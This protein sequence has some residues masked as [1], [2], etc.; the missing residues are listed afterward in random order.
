MCY[1]V[2]TALVNILNAISF[3]FGGRKNS[4][5]RLLYLSVAYEPL[6]F[7][8]QDETL[9]LSLSHFPDCRIVINVK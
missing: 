3:S 4:V 8:L 7:G 9:K 6:I 2:E 1:S 5:M